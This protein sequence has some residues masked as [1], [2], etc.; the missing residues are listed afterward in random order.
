M[1]GIFRETDRWRLSS[2]WFDVCQNLAQ[3][4]GKF[5]INKEQISTFFLEKTQLVHSKIRIITEEECSRIQTQ[6]WESEGTNSLLVSHTHFLQIMLPCSSLSAEWE[7][8]FSYLFSRFETGMH[9]TSFSPPKLK[10]AH[11]LLLS[12]WNKTCRHWVAHISSVCIH[13][14]AWAASR[15]AFRSLVSL[16]QDLV[17]TCRNR[18]VIFSLALWMMPRYIHLLLTGH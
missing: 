1:G 17:R 14:V 11:S 9:F 2:F 15:S 16:L 13:R 12:S 8:S 5:F 18:K 10:W 4:G 6:G 7:S 3:N